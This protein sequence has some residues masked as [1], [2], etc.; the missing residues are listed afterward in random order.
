MNILHHEAIAD[1]V[2]FTDTELVVKLKDA[3]TIMVPLMW[4][5]KLESATTEQLNNFRFIGG[6]RGIHWEALDEDLSVN[7]FLKGVALTAA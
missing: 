6:G 5:P 4:Y 1:S 3:R 2:S 7:G